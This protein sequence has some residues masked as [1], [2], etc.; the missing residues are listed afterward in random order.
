M[1]IEKICF[2]V[3]TLMQG[4]M[5]RVVA[6]LAN[7]YAKEGYDV[8]IICMYKTPIKYEIDINV[9][10]I[11]PQTA[12][13]DT[14]Y[15][16]LLL[17]KILFFHLKKH[18]KDAVVFGFGERFNSITVVICRF[19]NIRIFISD[20]NNP[21]ASNGFLNDKLRRY[22]YPLA[23]GVFA[24]TAFAKEHFLKLKLNNNIR[25][26]NNPLK[27]IKIFP[28]CTN[29]KKTIITVGR[30]DVGKNHGVLIDL[31][32][33]IG[34]FTWQL[35]IVGDGILRK[36]LERKIE[37]LGLKENVLLVGASDDV[38]SWLNK[39]EIFA[40]TSLHEGFPNALI[41]AMA[42]PLAC[43]SYDCPVGPSEIIV[44][45]ENGVLIPFGEELNY[46]NRLS[47]LMGD[48]ELRNKLKNKSILIREKYS[49]E[50]V[51]SELIKFVKEEVCK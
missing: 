10:I 28:E 40:F 19:L 39:A 46:V 21:L 5:E 20:R 27:K 3:P 34:D 41:E 23:N 33:K 30:L 18:S 17:F 11:M 8:S 29:D 25:V 22:I 36:D 48:N 43:I 51:A 2:V 47:D 42:F 1:K 38:D 14:I 4:G 50:Q 49:V 32:N 16:K 37:R 12:Y 26:I 13:P 31:F 35:I 7:Y 24:Q 6:V 15:G 9:K 45:G 44:D